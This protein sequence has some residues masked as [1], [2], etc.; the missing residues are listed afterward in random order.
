LLPHLSDRLFLLAAAVL[1]ST[2][3][4]AIKAIHLSPWQIASFRSGIAAA[5]LLILLR[6]ARKGWGVRLIPASLAYAA[7]LVA[8]VVATKLTTAANAIFLQSAA[9]LYLLVIGPLLLHERVRRSDLAFAGAVVTGMAMMLLGTEAP[10]ATTPDPGRGDLIAALSGIAWAFTIAALRW[11]GR[12]SESGDAISAVAAGNA[13]ACLVAFPV[14]LPLQSF[15]AAD[16]AA[17][18]Y[19][20]VVQIGLAY[21]FLTRGLRRV[22]AFEASALLL[23]EP[24]LNPVWAWLLHDEVPGTRAAAGGAVILAA[25]F[26]KTWKSR[27]QPDPFVVKMKGA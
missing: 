20:G 11:V 9:P 25:V 3:G 17:L 1:F 13:V 2:G 24:V 5:A 16:L 6:P 4:A 18:F 19:L 23:L 8:F 7:T 15:Q 10:T 22:S 14:A 12:H 27:R 21:V 26:I